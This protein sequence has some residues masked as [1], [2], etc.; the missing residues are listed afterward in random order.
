MYPTIQYFSDN[1]VK[2]RF[3]KVKMSKGT[4]F[5]KKILFL[6]RGEGNE[7]ERK[8]NISVWLPLARPLP[9]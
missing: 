6:Q 8:K 2:S 3:F 4:V 5:F 9:W 1:I 7:K